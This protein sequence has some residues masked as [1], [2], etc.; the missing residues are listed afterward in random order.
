MHE[1]TGGRVTFL[2]NLIFSRL[3]KFDGLIFG[4]GVYTVVRE[5]LIILTTLIKTN[6]FKMIRVICKSQVS[7]IPKTV[8]SHNNMYPW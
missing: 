8:D 4:E 3:E 5:G 2:V 1:N 7:I 6:T